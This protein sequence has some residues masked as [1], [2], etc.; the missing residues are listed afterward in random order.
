MKLE[1]STVFPGTLIFSP[2]G[3]FLAYCARTLSNHIKIIDITNY[4]ELLR[5]EGH[6]RTITSL[7]VTN[8]GDKIASGLTFNIG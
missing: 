3:S 2:I 6:T 8:D 1:S 5:L 4:K 7:A